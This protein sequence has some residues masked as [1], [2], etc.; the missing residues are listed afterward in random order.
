MPLLK[1]KFVFNQTLFT[2]FR[3]RQ[4]QPSFEDRF[5]RGIDFAKTEKN[6]REYYPEQEISPV[7]IRLPPKATFKFPSPWA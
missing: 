6:L 5:E 4:L 2:L 7:Q 3:E 1:D